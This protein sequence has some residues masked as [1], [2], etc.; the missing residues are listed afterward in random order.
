MVRGRGGGEAQEAV[1]KEAIDSGEVAQYKQLLIFFFFKSL[2][3]TRPLRIKPIHYRP[4]ICLFF[5]LFL[6]LLLHYHLTFLLL[7]LLPF[8]F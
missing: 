2:D 8:F 1:G 4:C 3:K 7:F 5:F 6:P